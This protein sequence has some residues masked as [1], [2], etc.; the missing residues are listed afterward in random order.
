MNPYRENAP[1][2]IYGLLFC[3]DLGIYRSNT[4]ARDIYPYDILFSKS[5]TVEDF[6]KIIDDPET[7]TRIKL[8]AYHLQRADGHKPSKKEL[9][10]VIIEV[11]FDDGLDVLASYKDGTA[12]YIN[13]TGS[14]VIWETKD[15]TSNALTE[16]LFRNSQVI[17]NQIGPWD[18]PRRPAPATGITR[19]SFL[20]SDG[21]Y[22]GEGPVNVLFNDPMAAPAF[23]SGTAL[24]QFLTEK[25][26]NQKKAV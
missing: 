10:A 4:Q 1:N 14:M 26:L 19:I 9:L 25:A 13:H 6:Q 12:R 7:E 17:V 15:E 16:N 3:D 24:M 18:K 2:L 23:Q 5:S 8:L 22:F 20:V 11:G 21:L